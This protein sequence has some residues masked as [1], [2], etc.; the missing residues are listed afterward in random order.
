MDEE[1]AYCENGK[2]MLIL[3]DPG[4]RPQTVIQISIG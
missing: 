2:R 4:P 1:H 3:I